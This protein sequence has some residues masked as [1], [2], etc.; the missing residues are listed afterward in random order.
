MPGTQPPGRGDG[1]GLRYRQHPRSHFQQLTPQFEDEMV[2]L[3][4]TT[5]LAKVGTDGASAFTDQNQQWGGKYTPS[6]QVSDHPTVP[7]S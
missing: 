6:H 3:V 4:D 1:L 5:F 2:A 7:V